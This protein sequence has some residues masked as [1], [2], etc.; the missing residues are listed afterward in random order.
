MEKP[1]FNILIATPANDFTPE[2][3]ISLLKTISAIQAE[4]LTWNFASNGGSLVSLVR[5]MTIAGP[6]FNNQNLTQP[7]NGD[8]T[9]DSIIWIDSDISWEP[10]DIFRLYKSDKPIISGCY[11][12]ESRQVPIYKEVLGP[13]MSEDELLSKHSPFKVFG[14]GFGFLAVKSGV[15]EN[16]PRPWFGPVS[17]DNKDNLLLIGEDLSWSIKA[18]QAGFELWAD[19]QVRVIHKKYFPLIW[20]DTIEQLSKSS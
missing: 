16:I 19:P 18:M 2:Y 14:V 20:K 11:L 3:V 17:M 13:M 8:F 6:D 7:Y 15:F 5:E 12:N 4:G 9:Y 10:S 1:H